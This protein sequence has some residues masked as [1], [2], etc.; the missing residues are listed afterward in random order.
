MSALR[1]SSGQAAREAVLLPVIFLTVTLLGG[2]Q[3][4]PGIA[5]VP[6]S[7]FS[8]VLGTMVVGAL[9]RAGA[10]APDRLLHGS[11]SMLANAN[12]MVVLV[13]LF[14]AASQVLSMLTPRSGLPLF[15]VD[16]FLFVLLVNTLVAQPD[17]VRLLRSLAVILGSGLVL[18]FVVL[19]ALSGPSGSRT[20]RVLMALFDAATFGAIAQEPQAPGAGYLAFFAIALFL[21]GVGA[22]PAA[23]PFSDSTALEVISPR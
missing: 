19:A 22:L 16:V 14:A 20:A 8:L 9:V 6:P 15:F 17:R 12:G 23:R 7:V 1:Q 21:A 5:L 13:S 18:K 11:R 10:L 4:G 2:V 3:L